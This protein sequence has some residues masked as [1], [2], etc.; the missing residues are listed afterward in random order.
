MQKAFKE[1]LDQLNKD[2][3]RQKHRDMYQNP[4]LLHETTDDVYAETAA[5]TSV[6][7]GAGGGHHTKRRV[8]KRI[9]SAHNRKSTIAANTSTNASVHTTRL[10]N[11][12]TARHSQPSKGI[13]VLK[14][15]IGNAS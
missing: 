11:K 3:V 13:Y 7:M 14:S 1:C 5:G 12:L 2:K 4:N 15:K 8:H 6:N 9:Q 10:A